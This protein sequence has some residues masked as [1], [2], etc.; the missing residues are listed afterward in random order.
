MRGVLNFEAVLEKVALAK[1][2]H[3]LDEDLDS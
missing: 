1:S 3:R 2:G